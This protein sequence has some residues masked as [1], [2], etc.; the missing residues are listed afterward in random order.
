[1]SAEDYQAL[2]LNIG[3]PLSEV[4]SAYRHLALLYHPDRCNGDVSVFNQTRD[5]YA[6]IV[7]HLKGR[8]HCFTHEEFKASYL[9]A[10]ASAASVPSKETDETSQSQAQAQSQFDLENFNETFERVSRRN[11]EHVLNLNVPEQQQYVEQFKEANHSVSDK[12][13]KM[14]KLFENETAFDSSIFNRYFEERNGSKT[15]RN[16]QITDYQDG[17]PCPVGLGPLGQPGGLLDKYVANY[18]GK[19]NLEFDSAFAVY[20]E[21]EQL[22]ENPDKID[23]S[24]LAPTQTPAPAPVP[25]NNDNAKVLKARLAAALQQRK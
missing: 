2:G 23:R 1:M 13:D 17:N 20:G 3:A 5:S 16:Q 11:T 4:R 6:R 15:N 12:L 8:N 25:A 10:A 21:V 18:D 22:L 7:E 24:V 19:S 14:P 9:S